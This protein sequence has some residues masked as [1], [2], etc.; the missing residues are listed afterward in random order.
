MTLSTAPFTIVHVNAA[1]TRITG[2]SSV[3][4]LGRSFGDLIQGYK[5]SDYLLP[6]EREQQPPLL[7]ILKACA[8]SM[9][10]TV[11]TGQGIK[12]RNYTKS[13]RSGYIP[14]SINVS[15]V[16]TPIQSATHLAMEL[17]LTKT[18]AADEGT[19]GAISSPAV[20]TTPSGSPSPG[21]SDSGSV[22][23]F[24]ETPLACGGRPVYQVAG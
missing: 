6:S 23:S 8:E 17:Q 9:S 5:S 14:C 1:F 10:S 2:M 22:G 20:G 4:T 21:L 7:E 16:G 24:P 13:S 3:K 18:T 15:P 12:S 19:S 11:V